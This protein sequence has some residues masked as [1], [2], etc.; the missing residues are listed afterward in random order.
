LASVNSP[1]VANNVTSNPAKDVSPRWSPDGQEILFISDR[2]GDDALYITD[3]NGLSTRRLTQDPR[4]SGVRLGL[5]DWS[6]NSEKI[7]VSVMGD[8]YIVDSDGLTIEHVHEMEGGM[9]IGHIRWSPDS[10][11]IAILDGAAE[12]VYVLELDTGKIWMVGEGNNIDWS[13]HGLAILNRATSDVTVVNATGKREARY[14]IA[15]FEWLASVD[16]APVSNRLIVTGICEPGGPFVAR[17]MQRG[18]FV[19]AEFTG[20][21]ADWGGLPLSLG[22]SSELNLDTWGDLKS[23]RAWVSPAV[24]TTRDR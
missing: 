19:G 9:F 22:E 24:H 4:I 2:D 14:P 20:G 6:I 3:R 13:R 18:R 7:A 8:V 21:Y 12:T 10:K 1:G 23:G 5:P 16:F 17:V 11:H 15:Q